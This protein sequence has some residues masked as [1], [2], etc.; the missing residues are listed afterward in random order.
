MLLG[1]NNLSKW[2]SKYMYLL[3]WI[4]RWLNIKDENGSLKYVWDI[5]KLLEN[6][7]I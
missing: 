4:F 6:E 1:F 2:L 5:E 3:S 7:K